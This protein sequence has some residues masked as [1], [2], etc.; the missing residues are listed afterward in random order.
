MFDF[1]ILAA[2]TAHAEESAGLFQALGIDW[3][4][5]V[6][7]SLAFLI[8]V[9]LLAKFVYPALMRAVDSRREAIEAGLREAKQSQ[10]AAEKAE[11]QIA[12]MLESARKEADDI[13]ARTHQEAAGVLSE[14]E[15]KAKVRAEQIVADARHQLEN[16]VRKA[17]EALKRDTVQLVA[18]ATEK[19]VGEK[20]D[21]QK[22]AGLIKQALA[23]EKA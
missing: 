8:L 11:A 20:I 5:L 21:G 3:K 14:A 7:Q 23:Q 4:L 22:D 18:L 6:E 10:E 9:L 12:G 15:E 19:V 16:D 1:E 2:A 13:L 17:R